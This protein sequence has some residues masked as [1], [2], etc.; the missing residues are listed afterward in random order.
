MSLKANQSLFEE[1]KVLEERDSRKEHLDFE[2]SFFESDVSDRFIIVEFLSKITT[3]RV[4]CEPPSKKYRLIIYFDQK[5][6][7]TNRFNISCFERIFFES[8]QKTVFYRNAFC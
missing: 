2:Q 7:E 6:I 3:Q 5:S 4:S 8:G 1:K